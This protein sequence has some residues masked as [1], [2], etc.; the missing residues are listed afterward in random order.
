MRYFLIFILVFC[1]NSF[2]VSF[3]GVVKPIYEAKVSLET[4]GIVSS[5]YLKE[6]DRVRNGDVILRLDDTLQLLETKRRKIIF[7][8]RT[9]IESAKKSFDILQNILEKKEELYRQTKAVSLNNLNQLRMQYIKAKG[10][11]ESLKAR[12]FKEQIEYKISKEVLEQ[13][14]LR[15]PVNGTITKIVP[16]KG[17]W[18]QTSNEVVHIV[19]SDIC[20]VEIDIDTST[21]SLLELNSEVLIAFGEDDS[22][23]EKTGIVSFI[24]VIADMSSGLVRAKVQF[25]N[26]D[27][28]IIPGTTAVVMIK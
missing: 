3:T 14:K 5:I 9:E 26:K 25:D 20:Y 2:A 27:R 23:V 16:K 13:Y 11:I 21:L 17:E 18:V 15:S 4:D 12:E 22:K 10:E 8:D 7:E 24:S 1:V 6:G 28:I 19:D